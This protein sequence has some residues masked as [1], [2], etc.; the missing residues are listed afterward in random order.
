MLLS[1]VS[2]PILDYKKYD[3]GTTPSGELVAEA[4]SYRQPPADRVTKVFATY[5]TEGCIR[6]IAVI[7]GPDVRVR[8]KWLSE[9][10]LQVEHPDGSTVMEANP[11]DV[12]VCFTKNVDATFVTF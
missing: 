9:S 12:H 11:D 3:S 6:E 2:D 7:S 8:L 1:C 4:Y 5:L 10:Q